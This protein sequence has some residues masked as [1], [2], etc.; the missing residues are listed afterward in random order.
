MFAG[1]TYDLGGQVV[2]AN[3][4]PVIL[5]LG[6]EVGCELEELDDHNLAVVDPSSGHFRAMELAD[7]YLSAVSLTLKLQDEAE[8]SGRIGV[9]AM[10][11]LAPDAAP[12]F[13]AS[14]GINSVP[15]SVA[16]GYTASGY[17]FVQDMPYA[18]LHE[19]TRTSMA[20]KVRRF[21]GG[22]T[23]FWQK[24]SRSLPIDLRCNARVSSIRRGADTIKVDVRDNSSTGGGEV[25][26]LEF[27][28][29]IISG[30]FPFRNCRTYH[31][32]A[33]DHEEADG[34]LMDMSELEEELFAKVE[35]VDYY[36]TVLKIKGLD[37]M[38]A[39]FYH[40]QEYMKSPSAIGHPVA[41]QRFH[42]DTD[43]F[44]FWSYGNSADIKGPQVLDMAVK[45]VE[46]M[47][48]DVAEVVLQRRFKYF[49]HVNCQ[50]MKDGF[51]DRLEDELQ[52]QR[53][54]YYVGGLMAF[55]LTERN[56]YY[57]IALMNKHFATESLPPPFPYVKRLHP[58]LS[59]SED[60][61]SRQQ[62][63]ELAG[64]DYP[65]L[66]S[67]DA[68]L[69]HWAGHGATKDRCL[70]R[71]ID[72]KG[73]TVARRTYAE[74]NANASCIACKLRTD[75]K[76]LVKP[77]DRVLLV[78]VPGLD[79]IDAFFGCVRAGV[80]PVPALPPDPSKRGG[81]GQSLLHIQ[82]IAT[83]CNAVA[84]LS[85]F[86]YRTSVQASSVINAVLSLRKSP[87]NTPK[88]PDLPWFNTDSWVR[89][90]GKVAAPCSS[91][92][93]KS[94]P[95]PGE[96]CFLQYT[97][98]ST[99]DAKGVM[100]THGGLIHNVQLMRRRYKSTSKT[101]LVSWLPQYHDMGLIGGFFTTLVS[102]GTAVVF[103]PLTFIKNPL[104]WLETISR[105]KATH[106]A[107]PN[108]AF[109]LLVKRLEADAERRS[110]L[111]L[112]SLAFLMVA[113]EPVR[114]GTLRR[115]LELT[116]PLGMDEKI[117]APGYG[118]AENCVFVSCAFGDGKPVYVDWQERVCCGY[119]DAEDP[120]VDIR[121]ADP[122]TGRER[123]NSESEGEVW[124]SSPSAGIG[125]WGQEELSR[126][127]FKNE[128]QGRPGKLYTRTGD[129]GRIIDGKLFIT[130]R[131][132]DMIIVSGRNVYSSDVEKTVEGACEAVRPGCC[133]AIGV[134]EEILA[135]KGLSVSKTS[136]EV[137]LVVVAELRDGKRASQEVTEQIQD[138]IAEEHGITV[139]AVVLIKPRTITKTTSGKIKRYECLR[140]F[141]DGTL[142]LAEGHGASKQRSSTLA[143]SDR[144]KLQSQVA[145]ALS[146]TQRIGKKEITDFLKK[147]LSEQTGI[148]IS[149]ISVTESLTSYGIDSIGVVRAAQ[150]LSAFLGVPV[151]AID[152]FT[153]TSID[154][155]AIFAESLLAKPEP[156][157]ANPSLP[158]KKTT[159]AD[160]LATSDVSASRKV[161]IWFCHLVS[162]FY[163]A[164]ILA[165]PAYVAIHSLTSLTG[166]GAWSDYVLYLVGAPLAWMF[167]MAATCATIALFGNPYLQ[168]NYALSSEMSIWSLAFVKWRAL[169][170]L[171]EVSSN[172]LAVH[173]RNSIFLKH[174]FV[175]LGAEIGSSVVIDTVSI[176]DPYLVSVGDGAVIAE[177]ALV[178][179]HEVK[180]GVLTLAP[181]TIGRKSS[182]GP[183]AVVQIGSHV[184]DDTEV[185]PL[186]TTERIR[187]TAL[188]PAKVQNQGGLEWGKYT[189]IHQLAGIYSVGLLSTISAALTYFT[190][191]WLCQA[192]PDLRHFRLLC[193]CGAFHWFPYAIIAY[194]TIFTSTPCDDAVTFAAL[195]AVCY[196]VHGLVLSVLTSIMAYCLA[197]QRDE[198]TLTFKAWVRHRFIVA[199]HLRFG[200]LITGTEA[201]CAYLRL[202]GAT[203]GRDCSIRAI[204]PILNPEL[205]S[206][207]SGVH[208][209]DFSRV[210]PGFCS[211]NGFVSGKIQV[212]NN[213]V[214]GSQSVIL[215]GS[216]LQENVILGALSAAPLNSTLQKGGVFVGSQAPVMVKNTLIP[217]DDRIE[218]M[219][220]KYKRILSNLAASFASTTLKVRSR[221]FHRIGAAGK[222]CL[223]IYDN[224]RGFPEHKI[225]GSGKQ[226]PVIIRHSNCL[227]ADDDARKDPRGAALS[228]LN[229]DGSPLFDLT[230]KTGRAFH[231]RS[232][233]DFAT[234]LVC[235]AAAREEHVKR[236][237]HIR[238]AMWDSLRQP[239][240][241][242]ELHYYSNICRVFRFLD[243]QEM[244][245]KIKIRPD[246]ASIAEDSGK[247]EPSGI[248]PP[249]TGAIPRDE[250]DKRPLLFL[251]E[252]FMNRVSSP[253]G[254]R[255]VLQLQMQPIPDDKNIR[256]DSLDCT[257]PW[258]EA[259]Y[260]F[261]DIG[262]I[263]I[264]QQLTKDQSESLAFN[265]F[266]R[267]NEV[268]I[269]RAS[270]STES[271]SLDH[272]R[273]LV[274]AICQHLRNQT[275]LPE[276]WRAFLDQSDVKVDLRGCPMAAAASK[277][278]VTSK[279]TLARRWYQEAWAS[280]AQPQLQVTAPYFLLGLVVF[281]PLHWMIHLKETQN[282][283]PH[284]TF[285]V[286]WVLTGIMSASACAAMK[287]V[288]VGKK[289]DGDVTMIW[290]KRIFMD[291]VWQAVRTVV[292]EYF[293]E[294]TTGSP[295]FAAWMKLMGADIEWN[296]GAYV[297]SMGA[298]LNPDMVV[299][300]RGA[301][302]ERDALLFGHI[303]EGD[304]GKVKYGK[305]VVEERGFVGSRAVVM[306]GAIVEREAS[307]GA[308]SLAMKE[309]VVRSC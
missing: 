305:I 88:W 119:V 18:Y 92:R 293:M 298:A 61:L 249:E 21:K 254:V 168:P 248:L 53:N 118:L 237:P 96:L 122:E 135:A 38:P 288:L 149:K 200:K 259:K 84:I 170:K 62:L 185:P 191:A 94:S 181:I 29:L 277:N 163:I 27:D 152:I 233:A 56:S 234:W 228:I 307:L 148:S 180:R 10:S 177:G 5:H 204:N 195:V 104:L 161:F 9:H 197:Q 187:K 139:A 232:I 7:D 127:T 268:D 172:V 141:A 167:C 6:R 189:A 52:G 15:N 193:I 230:L 12:E 112:G 231:A 270:S 55:E 294:M 279:V 255:Y 34:E 173:L 206:I 278:N 159:F 292:G 264:D 98:G 71:W 267:C 218:E 239:D 113:A 107:G 90:P 36:T 227:S 171:H 48:G 77:G 80:V 97:S 253:G 236:A 93:V 49:P 247:V 214:L 130:G 164:A 213:C 210:V 287:W 175:L 117:L 51:Y 284:R 145:D 30:S 72:D 261:I 120:D 251:A 60:W 188:K 258:D 89:K 81:G 86:D 66:P 212:G 183:Y 102:G 105:H 217:L 24:L 116:K 140:R 129:L 256:D 186:Q 229:G 74:L 14:Y 20:G 57:S 245:V 137:G 285:P 146:P 8:A 124:I 211:A 276:A 226:Y 295:V 154:D 215:P 76:Q 156:Q 208:L 196:L 308:M 199:C 184:A 179:S 79:F 280:L 246:D 283:P 108:F 111:D 275:P 143:P 160:N 58:L 46:N 82:N 198:S 155:L 147:L 162:L 95:A 13:L 263:T 244:F 128:L 37:H 243:G 121:I 45:D 209:G 202:L 302:A 75:K 134:P 73:E 150:K 304:E 297:D 265:P 273:S 269:I 250:D 33:S 220:T 43:I 252:D 201:F 35:T 103:S 190:C 207:G 281:Y 289:R 266:L 271:A 299:V 59:D 132:K 50:D 3:S 54:T 99:G 63:D 65:S 110:R 28:K 114:P 26:S 115:F 64:V 44:L 166:S 235:G 301:S 17:G 309:E 69:E 192:S 4:A 242:A 260:P 2:T 216:T 142:S 194:A 22:Y 87:K 151:G 31:S 257:K 300:G 274:Y 219:D 106:S 109:E 19:F 40:F 23:S 282:L 39:G 83:S 153:A 303:Y 225:F 291:T 85:T 25:Q 68:Y 70:Y 272:G 91:D 67:L 101:V 41:M 1:R 286:V 203:I 178:Q 47:G 165:C 238:E 221:Y 224:I 100:I 11:G 123:P 133:A 126:K 240:S 32:P 176:T 125:Y 182:V 131:I 262:E 222:G 174:W 241:Y 16:V 169:S 144:S 296:G 290:S 157:F 138:C 205:V 158:E 136:D 306:P 223:K 78:Y 42:T